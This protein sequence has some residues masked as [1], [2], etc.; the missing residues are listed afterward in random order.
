VDQRI[1]KL[2][3]LLAE[4]PEVAPGMEPAWEAYRGVLEKELENAKAQR[5]S[6]S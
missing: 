5:E 6:R 4:K 3:E 2:Q 1:V